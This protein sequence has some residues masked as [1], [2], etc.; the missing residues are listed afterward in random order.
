M[1]E[2]EDMSTTTDHTPKM[3]FTPLLAAAGR[4][5]TAVSHSFDE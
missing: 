4:I 2:N 5:F 3:T 1:N